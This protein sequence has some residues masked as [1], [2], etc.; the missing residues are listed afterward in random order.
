MHF[1]GWR[2]GWGK[3]REDIGNGGA[4]GRGWGGEWGGEG[5]EGVASC[6]DRTQIGRAVYTV[7]V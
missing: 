5:G 4:E 1:L 3:G 6:V 7:C 2:G